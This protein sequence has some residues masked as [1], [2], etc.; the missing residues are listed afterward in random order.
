MFSKSFVTFV[1]LAVLSG[2]AQARLRV[3]ERD[4][5][6]LYGRRF[7]QENPAVVSSFFEI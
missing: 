3:V 7:G 2:G 4:G 1:F 6:A 5:R